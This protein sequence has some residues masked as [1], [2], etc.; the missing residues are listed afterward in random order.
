[1]I[2]F[3]GFNYGKTFY[4][5]ETS[6]TF[7][8]KPIF[9]FFFA[10]FF[11]TIINIS[12]ALTTVSI[13][14]VYHVS[15]IF[16]NP[17]NTSTNTNNP[18]DQSVN[19][20]N[21]IQAITANHHLHHQPKYPFNHYQHQPSL[22]LQQLQQYQQ[23]QQ[24]NHQSYMPNIDFHPL[25]FP[26]SV[27]LQK[28]NLAQESGIATSGSTTG[29]TA[30]ALTNSSTASNGNLAS[31]N[32]S[33]N[34]TSNNTANQ[35]STTNTT[36]TNNVPASSLAAAIPL[37]QL[38]SKPAA[39]SA[40]TSLSALGGLTELLGGLTSLTTS[41]PSTTASGPPLQT[42]GAYRPKPLF[43]NRNPRGGIANSNSNNYNNDT[44]YSGKKYNERSKFNP[45]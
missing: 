20:S 42:T 12:I 34:S 11:Y 28:A 25:I 10:S 23:Q 13:T 43:G 22:N 40:L 7:V 18:Y 45:Y 33:A 30:L 6:R 32:N 26:Y 37:A 27:E 39:L 16:I 41:L 17:F 35:A 8:L 24:P 9:I 44:G 15:I 31:S 38:L 21:N 2:N 3:V 5:C 36:T 1:M 4:L 14:F 29:S 19:Q